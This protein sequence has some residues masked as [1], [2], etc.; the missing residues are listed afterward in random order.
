M[1]FTNNT[2]T[3][4]IKRYILYLYSV[5]NINSVKNVPRGTIKILTL[6][7][8]KMRTA[9]QINKLFMSGKMSAADAI[10][11]ICDNN[12]S[13]QL[14]VVKEYLE[15][16]GKGVKQHIEHG[17]YSLTGEIVDFET[18]QDEYRKNGFKPVESFVG[19][20]VGE[21]RENQGRVGEIVRYELF[22]RVDRVDKYYFSVH[23]FIG[24][25]YGICY[26]TS[27]AGCVFGGDSACEDHY[28]EQYINE[29]YASWNGT[30]N[31]DGRIDA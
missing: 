1:L 2:Y 16:A 6:K 5:N 28:N 12:I 10:S 27:G 21:Y 4:A 7:Q 8:V 31:E 17:P 11:Y 29:V 30:L 3:L 19:E 23:Q 22:K 25:Q 13:N 26:S 9:N 18:L 14:R 20:Y 15:I 24:G